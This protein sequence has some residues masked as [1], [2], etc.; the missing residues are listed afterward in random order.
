[1]SEL[2]DADV[3]DRVLARALANGGRFAELFAESRQGLTMS[4][5][6]SRLEAVQ[7]G[8]EQ[9]A[10]VRVIDGG[11]TYFAHVDGLAPAD[12]E[13]A[14]DEAAAA[15]RGERREPRALEAVATA[16]LPIARRPEDVPGE[17]KASLLR[18]L[19]ERARGAGDEVAQFTASYA[20][21]RR[22]IAVA[23]SDGLFTGDDRT[24]TRIGAQAVARREG[25]V[26]TGAETLGAHRGFELLEDDPGQI[27]E[28]AAR[29]AL[30]LLDAGP[31]PS[32]PMPVVV[33]GGFGGVLFHEMTGHGLEADHIQK[34]ASVYVGKL[35][36]Q[37]A[38]PLLNAY[39]DG[40]LPHEWGSDAIDDEG[41]ATQKT[42][43]IEEGRLTS[44]LYDRLTAERDGV[45]ATGNGRRESF[46]HLPIPRMTNTYIAPGEA[47]PEAIDRR[48]RE[49]LLRGLLRRRPGRPGDRRLRLRRLRGVPDRGRRGDPALPRRDP[50]R[51]LPRGADG[52]R[53][54]RRRLLH[55]DRHLRQGRAESTG[56]DRP[57]PRPR[58]LDDGRGD[59]AVTELSA[60]AARAVE[61]ALGAG[62]GEAEVYASRESGREVRV[63]GGEVESLTAATQSGIG[64]R[65]WNGGRVGYAFGTDLSAAGVEAI[66]ARAAE[67]A[68]VADADE[69]A[70]PPQPAPVEALPGLSDPSL[71]TW[72]TAEVAELALAVERAALAVDSRV[73]G[74]EQVV[75][76]DSAE[77]VAIASSTGIAGEF[78]SSDCFAYAQALAEGEGARQTGLGFG[79]ARGPGGLDPEAIGNE[80]A[81]RA[82]AMIGAAKPSSRSCPV[83]LD[84][85]VA[86]SFAG[87]I[88]G[89]L[90]ASAVQRGRS[91]FAE[92]LGEELA[93]EALALHDD[94]RDPAGPASAPF[95]AEGVPRRRTALLEGGRLRAFLYDTYTA[96][97]EGVASTGSASRHG[98]RSQPTVSTSNL[99]VAAGE[100]SFAELLDAAGEAVLVTDVAGLHS[101]V[102]PVTGVFSVGASGR[103]VRGGELAEPLR[104]F[105]IASDLVTMLR[106]GAGGRRGGPLG[107]VRRLGSDAAAADRRDGRQRFV[108]KG[109]STACGDAEAAVRLRRSSNPEED[110]R[111]DQG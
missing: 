41:A 68:A 76:A 56:R 20:E 45:A 77:R 2:I 24:R 44:Y 48:G 4:I 70:V 16:P 69:F 97:R 95:D 13:R 46:R 80:A 109:I 99:L 22:Q 91:P 102:N 110:F 27:A 108:T 23:N 79:L 104:E 39:D 84:P 90:S 107:P 101:G 50:D 98:Y 88:G 9:G 63:H 7:S 12:L 85:T 55:E 72:T 71:A 18:E 105:T 19:D 57:G 42:Q 78:E 92:R 5:D 21:A 64:V 61:A 11:T 60:T 73:A 94:G 3:A 32:G 87:L 29:K 34:G 65:A 49:G 106:P 14:A 62:A 111:R 33:G 17:R 15:L 75:Y 66:A 30:T 74:V 37:V 8:A 43:V 67:A 26:E 6:E 103:A 25:V 51:Q 100:L 86:A 83:V 59:R 36:E 10:G 31:A 82:T 40:R 53:R 93:S 96:N 28:Q 54:G 58:R 47:T 38:Q 35:G 1:M 89:A 52:D 81:E